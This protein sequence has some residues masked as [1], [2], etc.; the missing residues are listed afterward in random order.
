MSGLT[1]VVGFPPAL[2]SLDLVMVYR[3]FYHANRKIIDHDGTVLA[4]LSDKS[5]SQMFHIPTFYVMEEI[6]KEYV[7]NMWKQYPLSFKRIINQHWLKEKGGNAT[8]VPQELFKSDFF[9][10]YHD[11]V[12]LLRSIMGLPTAAFFENWMFYLIEEIIRGK[13]KFHWANMFSDNLHN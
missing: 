6:G 7:E 3:E 1:K 8:K 2:I 9:K 10:E 12:T 5:T 4:D 13:T 11:L